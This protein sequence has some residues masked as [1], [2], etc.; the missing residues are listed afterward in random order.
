MD[1]WGPW[2][3]PVYRKNFFAAG[4]GQDE[5]FDVRGLRGTEGA[6]KRWRSGNIVRASGKDGGGDRGKQGGLDY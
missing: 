2:T 1:P 3:D 4:H 5:F 6:E